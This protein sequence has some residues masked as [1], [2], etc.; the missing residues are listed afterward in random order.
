MARHAQ[1]IRVF[2]G[3]HHASS[4]G[5]LGKALGTTAPATA[6][7]RR[8]GLFPDTMIDQPVYEIH[9]FDHEFG[10]VSYAR[11]AVA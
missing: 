11:V 9:V 4:S 5:T 2:C 7:D 3:H 6:I 1:I 10:F 8:E